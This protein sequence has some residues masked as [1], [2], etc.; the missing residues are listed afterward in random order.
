MFDRTLRH[1]PKSRPPGRT[2]AQ[3][4]RVKSSQQVCP[5]VV[6][7]VIWKER[8]ETVPPILCDVCGRRPAVVYCTNDDAHFCAGCDATHHSENE[9]FARHQRFSL[10][11]SPKQFGFCMHHPTQRYELVCLE[12]RKLLCR[13]D[14]QLGP[15]A[16]AEHAKHHLMS[17]LEVFKGAMKVGLC[18]CVCVQGSAPMAHALR[19]RTGRGDDAAL[20][21]DLRAL[22]GVAEDKPDNSY[23]ATAFTPHI[24]D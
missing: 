19:I 7:D 4:Y 13:N 10:E 6:V 2:N 3:V 18:V 12:E 16:S 23:R 11:H 9:F 5:I 15:H 21:G 8:K 17:T 14:I 1:K 20:Q 22:A 24:L